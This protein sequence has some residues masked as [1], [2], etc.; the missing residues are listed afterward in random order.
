MIVGDCTRCG[1]C[2][3]HFPLAWPWDELTADD[4]RWLAL[5]HIEIR[6]DIEERPIIVL[7][8]TCSALTAEGECAIYEERPE[9]CREWPHEESDLLLEPRCTLRFERGDA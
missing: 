6:R 1:D 3:R 7:P 2:C 4:E 8:S 9:C 5:H